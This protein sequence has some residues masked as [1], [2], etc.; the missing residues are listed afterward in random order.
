MLMIAGGSLRR[1]IGTTRMSD[2]VHACVRLPMAGAG[3]RH[4]AALE[5]LLHPR[6]S[7]QERLRLP[8]KQCP[9]PVWVARW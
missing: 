9:H 8:E 4:L 7:Q 6:H 5:I 2:G 1:R 3:H